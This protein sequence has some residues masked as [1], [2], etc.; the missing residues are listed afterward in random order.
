MG[1]GK[2]FEVQKVPGDGR[3]VLISNVIVRQ[4]LI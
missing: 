1:D 2:E 4:L 3:I